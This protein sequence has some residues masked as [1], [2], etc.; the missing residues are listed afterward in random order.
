MSLQDII[1]LIQKDGISWLIV[2]IIVTSLIEITPIKINPISTIMGWIGKCFNKET[3]EKLEKLENKLDELENKLNGHIE[4]S[5]I[6]DISA[7]RARILRFGGEIMGNKRIILKSK[8][9]FDFIITEC[10]KYAKYCKENNIPNGVAEETIK[11]IHHVYARCLRENSFL[12][13]GEE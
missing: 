2:F 12:K 13:P 3:I 8:E 6:K 7:I 5:T 9:E 1:N 10:D 11:E 4:E